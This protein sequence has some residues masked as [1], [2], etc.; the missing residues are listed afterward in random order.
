MTRRPEENQGTY[1][2][3]GF[4]AGLNIN[5]Y[6]MDLWQLVKLHIHTYI[7]YILNK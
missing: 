5:N 4:L 1:T 6:N 3:S 2:E 7:H